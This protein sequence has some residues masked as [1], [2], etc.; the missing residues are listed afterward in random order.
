[1]GELVRASSSHTEPGE[2]ATPGERGKTRGRGLLGVEGP[3][4]CAPPFLACSG[5][6]ER[7]VALFPWGLP[8]QGTL[9]S[10]YPRGCSAGAS[11]KR[12]SIGSRTLLGQDGE[13]PVG[14]EQ[15]LPRLGGRSGSLHHAPLWLPTHGPHLPSQL[16]V[17]SPNQGS[18]PEPTNIFVSP[19]HN[20][21]PFLP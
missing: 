4:Q 7:G 6:L 5:V 8:T 20:S 3:S 16:R 21:L 13:G 2:P 10:A 15:P 19:D 1:M 9:P 11:S 17:F 12:P 18:S 14:K